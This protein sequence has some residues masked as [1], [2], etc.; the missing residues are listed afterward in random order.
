[1]AIVAVGNFM[2]WG[3]FVIFMEKH[4]TI[5]FLLDVAQC[6]SDAFNLEPGNEVAARELI[7]LYI[8]YG[9]KLTL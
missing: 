8:F 6:R 2:A 1:M 7:I 5:A 4:M 9:G 3:R